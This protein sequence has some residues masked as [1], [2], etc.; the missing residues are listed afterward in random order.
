M[1]DKDIKIKVDA[2]INAEPT[3]K[4]LR[5]LKQLQKEVVAGSDDFKK[6]QARINDIGDAAKTAKGQSEDWIDTLGNLPGPLGSIGKGLDTFTSSTNKL[7]LAFKSLGIGLIVSAIGA[8][9]AAFSQNE[10]MTKKLEPLMI[11]FQKILGGIFAAIEPVIDAVITLAVNALPMVT[12][13]FKVVY[14]AMSSFLQGVGKIGSAIYK[15]FSGDFKGAWEDAKASVTDFGKRYDE[16]VKNF[17]KGAAEMTE[18]EKKNLEEQNK[19]RAEAAK[20]REEELKK[21][22]EA[23]Q[24]AL[25]ERKK[26]LDAEIQLETN[27][28]NTDRA[29]LEKLLADRLALE[30]KTGAE[31]ELMRQEN[32]K[33]VKE[34]IA[35]DLKAEEDKSKALEQIIK[36]RQDFNRKIEDLEIAAIANQQDREIAARQTKLNRDLEDLEMDK[37]FI[38]KSE[39]EKTRIRMLYATIADADMKKIK[40]G[41]QDKEDQDEAD[42]NQK[43]LRILELQGQSLIKGTRA[44]FEN[45]SAVLVETEQTELNQLKL[46]LQNKKITQEE[47]EKAVTATAQKYGQLRKN[48]KQEEFQAVAQTMSATFSA[49]ANLTNVLASSYDEEAKTSKEA[50][51]KRKKLQIATA[52]MSAASG[53]V[54]I[55]AQPSTLPSPFDFIVKG[56]NAAALGVSTAVNIAKIRKTSF[57]APSDGGAQ[58]RKLASGGYVSG[59]GTSTSD[60]IN[61]SL[62][63]GEF[64][65]NARATSAFLPLLNSINEAGR[66]P[67]FAMGGMVN[68]ANSGTDISNISQAITSSLADRPIKTYV[69]SQDMSNSQQFD[70]T[71]KSRSVI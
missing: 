12:D 33:K 34:A 15:L 68:G 46:D 58:R 10:K 19:K 42:R 9:T 62:S 29:R 54:Q 30:G 41:F 7:G 45:R 8:L 71:I 35:N 57:E 50:F 20:K 51:E 44:Y 25:E 22:K 23:E 65:V 4:A 63:N 43:R 18:I 61:A 60:S 53:I 3:L 47:Y 21:R 52:V 55:L 66:Q 26:Q 56:I 64:V 6:I 17:E 28:D 27:K 36:N 13:A 32:S 67:R 37:E 24:K 11:G 40:K 49:I 2:A 48:L 69:V 39:E 1:A 16:S 59:P 38:M 31:L 14:S 70:R 5:E